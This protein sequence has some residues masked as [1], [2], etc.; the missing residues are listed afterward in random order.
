[1]RRLVATVV[2]V[3]ALAAGLAPS[4]GAGSA[5]EPRPAKQ[6]VAGVCGELAIWQAAIEKSARTHAPAD[7]AAGKAQATKL[8]KRAAKATAVL[9]EQ[10]DALG[11][12]DIEGGEDVAAAFG[13]AVGARWPMPTRAPRRRPGHCRPTT[14]RHSRRPRPRS[15]ISSAWRA[16]NSRGQWM[17]RGRACRRRSSRKRSPQTRPAARSADPGAGA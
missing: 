10:L 15:P 3:T 1:M 17:R 5:P 8:V 4:A 14:T 16:P 6:W 7:A 13:D 2:C 9:G 12:P 11:A